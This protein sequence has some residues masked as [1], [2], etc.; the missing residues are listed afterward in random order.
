MTDAL[1]IETFDGG[2]LYWCR[3]NDLSRIVPYFRAET[4]ILAM[5]REYHAQKGIGI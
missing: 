3:Y 4:A 1:V 2:M 5:V